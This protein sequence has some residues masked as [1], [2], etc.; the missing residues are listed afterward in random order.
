MAN[1][2]KLTYFLCRSEILAFPTKRLVALRKTFEIAMNRPQLILFRGAQ[3]IIF[4]RSEKIQRRDQRK[5]WD[6][7]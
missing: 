3:L 4:L 5:E 2:L 6:A 7:K 1:W